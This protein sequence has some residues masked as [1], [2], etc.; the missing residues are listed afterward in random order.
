MGRTLRTRD[1]CPRVG[2]GGNHM[3]VATH[4]WGWPLTRGDGRSHVGMA[5]LHRGWPLTRGDGGFTPGD[6]HS[7]LGMV[8]LSAGI[9]KKTDEKKQ[10]R[11]CSPPQASSIFEKRQFCHSHHQRWRRGCKSS[12]ESSS[13]TRCRSH[14]RMPARPCQCASRHRDCARRARARGAAPPLVRPCR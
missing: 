14:R 13:A 10:G 9:A 1:G 12:V 5:G 8:G 11:R 3:G 6:S 2:D 4:T 7:H